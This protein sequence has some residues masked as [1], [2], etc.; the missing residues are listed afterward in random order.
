MKMVGFWDG[1]S[2]VYFICRE[3]ENQRRKEE[4]KEN[5]M[6]SLD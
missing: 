3:C 6:A 4:E 1:R 2:Q 5:T